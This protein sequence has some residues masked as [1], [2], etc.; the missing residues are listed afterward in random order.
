[1][2][3]LLVFLHLPP[4]IKLQKG[5]WVFLLL[6]SM[7]RKSSHKNM[8]SWNCI[9]SSAPVQSNFFCPSKELQLWSIKMPHRHFRLHLPRPWYILFNSSHIGVILAGTFIH[10]TS[11]RFYPICV[12]YQ[13][14]Q[15]LN[16]K[17]HCKLRTYRPKMFFFCYT[18]NKDSSYFAEKFSDMARTP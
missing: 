13:I 6:L 3:Q 7:Y 15:S 5:K 18:V 1:M 16:C 4:H 12:N 9:S 2:R 17:I 8:W 10:M 14:K 11:Y